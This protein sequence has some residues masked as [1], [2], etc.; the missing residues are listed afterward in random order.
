MLSLTVLA[1]LQARTVDEVKSEKAAMDSDRMW[2]VHKGGYTAV[3]VLPIRS[4]S[5]SNPLAIH[6]I[7]VRTHGRDTKQV[8][9][10][11][12]EEIM[13]VAEEDLE[14]VCEGVGVWEVRWCRSV[15]VW[16]GWCER[17]GVGCCECEGVGVL[18]GVSV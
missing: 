3:R 8:K 18:D 9:L 6:T 7:M 17:E 15:R 2:L 11:G 16:V 1:S 14:K 12:T 4:T 5:R 13:E 10:E